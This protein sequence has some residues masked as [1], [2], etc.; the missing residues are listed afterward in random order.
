MEEVEN[1]IAQNAQK[2][3]KHAKENDNVKKTKRRIQ[4]RKIKG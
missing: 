1:K 3:G 4:K 2:K